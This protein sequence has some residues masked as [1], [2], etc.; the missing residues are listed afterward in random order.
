MTT[1][2]QLH[3]AACFITRNFGGEDSSM[4]THIHDSIGLIR[5]TVALGLTRSSGVRRFGT[6]GGYTGR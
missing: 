1:Q 2:T 5:L 4:T 3:K 6:V